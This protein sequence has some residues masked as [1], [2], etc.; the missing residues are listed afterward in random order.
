MR[1]WRR[2]SHTWWLRQRAETGSQKL[3]RPDV[4]QGEGKKVEER[5]IR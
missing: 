5:K 2:I 4:L 3:I 1:L